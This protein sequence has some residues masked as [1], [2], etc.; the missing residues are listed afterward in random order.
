MNSQ[1]ENK[2][3][4]RYTWPEL[5]S[6]L[7]FIRE[8]KKSHET[9]LQFR[10]K[11]SQQNRHR[12]RRDSPS[13]KKDRSHR[14]KY[15]HQKKKKRKMVIGSVNYRPPNSNYYLWHFSFIRE[16]FFFWVNYLKKKFYVLL[17]QIWFSFQF[18]FQF[19]FLFFFVWVTNT[20]TRLFVNFDLVYIKF[21]LVPFKFTYQ[22]LFSK[23][24]PKLK[25]AKS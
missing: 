18:Q 14:S 20:K 19:Q 13:E 6:N 3:L 16:F 7:I 15:L 24:T 21:I 2:V 5:Y 9:L 12:E 10:L 25:R 8:Q 23:R 4:I 22:F 11:Q 17:V 1:R